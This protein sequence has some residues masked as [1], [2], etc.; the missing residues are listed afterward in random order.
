MLYEMFV[1]TKSTKVIIKAESK[2]AALTLFKQ[3]RGYEQG[4]SKKDFNVKL[5]K[6]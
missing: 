1:K 5:Y 6:E 4:V 3:Q 2:E